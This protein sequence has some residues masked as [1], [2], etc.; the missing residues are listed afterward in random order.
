MPFFFTRILN[1]APALPTFRQISQAQEQCGLSPSRTSS[2]IFSEFSSF[3]FPSGP[4]LIQTTIAAQ[5]SSFMARRASLK[6]RSPRVSL[7]QILF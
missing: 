6:A 4:S 2:D 1:F 3:F 7:L 5:R